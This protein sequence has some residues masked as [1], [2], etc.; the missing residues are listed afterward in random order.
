MTQFHQIPPPARGKSL[1][2]RMKIIAP[3]KCVTFA[4]IILR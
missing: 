3:V 4:A 2:E 1:H